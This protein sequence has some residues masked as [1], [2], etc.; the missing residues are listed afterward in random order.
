ML[1]D[2]YPLTLPPGRAGALQPIRRPPQNAQ[3][4]LFAPVLLASALIQVLCHPLVRRWLLAFMILD[5]PLECGTHLGFRPDAA[6]LGAIEGFDLSVTSLAL[7]GLWIG[8]IFSA[9]ARNEKLRFSVHWPIVAYT[10]IVAAS[11][12]VATDG[13]LSL[14]Q[15]FLLAQMLLF[16]IY[17]SSNVHSREEIAWIFWLLLAGAAVESLV[18]LAMAVTG[19]DFS[20]LRIF[21]MKTQIDLPGPTGGFTRPGGTVGS[22]NYTSAYLG[23]LMTLAVCVWQMQVLRRWRRLAIFVFFLAAMALACTFSRGGWIAVVLSLAILGGSRWHRGGLSRKTAAASVAGLVLAAAFLLVPNPISARALGDD[24]GSAHSRVP[25]MHLA[26]R[27]IEAN[28]LLGVGANNFGAVMNDYAGSEFRHEWIYTVH[29]QFLLVCAETGIIGLVAYLWVLLSVI[30]NG[31]RLW[32]VGDEMFSPLAL[33]MIAAV[34]GLMSHMFVD[35]F[36]GRAVVQL[37]WL[38]A[39]L[40]AAMGAILARERHATILAPQPMAANAR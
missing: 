35:I 10:L 8:W 21:G 24:E 6:V 20:F 30:R 13:T 29:N 16:Y 3:T 1:S 40:L 32:K 15:V 23:M 5:I 18:V 31:W 4:V 38:F 37:V 12:F 22:P 36:S 19:D 2:D 34:C 33:S 39:A 11:W 25:L 27:V 9:R 7:G 14:F 26:F 28:P 17:V